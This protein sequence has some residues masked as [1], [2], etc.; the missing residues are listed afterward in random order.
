MES[1]SSM[2]VLLRD[3]QPRKRWVNCTLVAIILA[4]VAL[5]CVPPERRVASANLGMLRNEELGLGGEEGSL[6]HTVARIPKSVEQRMTILDV[7]NRLRGGVS[8]DIER[9][10]NQANEL[11]QQGKFAQARDLY[12]KALTALR[13]DLEEPLTLSLLRNRAAAHMKL[14]H[15]QKA[16]D[17]A[18]TV[19]SVMPR[20]N[21]ALLRRSMAIDKLGDTKQY[22]TAYRD[23]LQ[24]VH[25]GEG[26]TGIATYEEVERMLNYMK[27][28]YRKTLH[29]KPEE[30]CKVCYDDAMFH[31]RYQGMELFDFALAEV[32]YACD[33]I[34]EH[35]NANF[36]GEYAY[37]CLEL[38]THIY[39]M[40]SNF[41]CL[42]DNLDMLI[43]ENPKNITLRLW[44][45]MANECCERY[46]KVKDE[47]KNIIDNVYGE[48]TVE[49]FVEAEKFYK[50]VKEHME[51]YN[52]GEAPVIKG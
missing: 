17:D 28:E 18:S 32:D 38:Q 45:C 25:E 49:Q 5:S 35:R 36:S 3:D 43:P 14:G 7:S 21:K 52:L 30:L 8:A 34:L 10:K 31:L 20:C 33:Y 6:G 4:I 47:A 46:K 40:Q 22:L 27:P 48:P 51:K 42:K 15:Y 11:F 13:M 23:L 2:P 1:A 26:A 44:R 37:K 41:D 29:D 16:V 9:Q 12:T 24:L 19:L 39:R 50:R